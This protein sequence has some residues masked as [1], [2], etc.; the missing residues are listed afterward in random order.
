VDRILRIDGINGEVLELSDATPVDHA[1]GTKPLWHLQA[2][3]RLAGSGR[4]ELA[5]ELWEC[6][7]AQLELFLAQLLEAQGLGQGTCFLATGS[8]P[9]VSLEV[10]FTNG[11]GSIEVAVE[12]W[13]A[14]QKLD[15][16]FEADEAAV[17]PA[18]GDLRVFV[19]R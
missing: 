14:D 9:D 13:D 17:D 6:D 16:R 11:T 15:L 12:V 19:A 18:I 1:P 5:M 7:P 8:Y 3:S 4:V 10:I 2:E